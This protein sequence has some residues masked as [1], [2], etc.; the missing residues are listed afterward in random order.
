MEGQ[1]LTVSYPEWVPALATAGHAAMATWAS[2]HVLLTKRDVRAAIGWI[3]LVWL[4]PYLGTGLYWMFGIN[5]IQR[6]ASSLRAKQPHPARA[7]DDDVAGEELARVIDPEAEHLA[8]LVVFMGSVTSR[9]LT[10]GNAV[11]PLVGGTESYEAMLSAIEGAAHSVGLASYIFNDDPVGRQ[12]VEA[13]S[14]ARD[15]GVEVRVLVDAVGARY[16]RPTI[17]KALHAAGLNAQT[18]LPSLAPSYFPYMNLRNHRKILVADNQVG[19]TGGM[20]IDAEFD[21]RYAGASARKDLHFELKG[22]IVRTLCEVFAE[23]W[24]FRT[25]EVLDGPAWSC[26]T[27]RHGEALARGVIDGPDNDA[28]VLLFAFL[29]GLNSA[30]ESVA[31]VTPYFLPDSRLVAAL[32]AAAMRGVIVEIFLPEINNLA[33]VQWASTAQYWQVLEHG[34]KILAVPPP[35]D[36]TK[37][38]VVDRCWTIFGSGNW[39]PRSLR[40]NFEFNVECYGRE[41]AGSVGTLIDD[42]RRAS[43]PVTLDEVDSRSLPVRLRDGAARLFSPYL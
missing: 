3:G 1:V 18:F 24:A 20:N 40:L 10:S 23:D 6:K 31:I 33:L 16:H 25:N 21:A 29:G 39:D 42:R 14:R 15:R 9:P 8:P 11:R 34:C 4:S 26:E 17:M 30:R 13:L 41:L 19:F 35:F 37:L 32:S 43:R 36:H 22:P 7:V 28:D 12:F 5:R 38:M 2:T 27:T